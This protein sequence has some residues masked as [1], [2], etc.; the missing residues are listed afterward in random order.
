[1]NEL[2]KK[3]RSNKSELMWILAPA[4][5]IISTIF[6]FGSATIYSGNISKFNVGFM[7]ILKYYVVP[8]IILLVISLQR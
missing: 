4:I 3:W 2:I 5:L 7:N 6:F 8:G 1:M